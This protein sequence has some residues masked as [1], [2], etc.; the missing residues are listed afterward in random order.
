[1]WVECNFLIFLHLI[2]YFFMNKS[3]EVLRIKEC[4]LKDC[5]EF[6]NR[7]SYVGNISNRYPLHLPITLRNS[8]NFIYIWLHTY[9]ILNY[10]DISRWLRVSTALYFLIHRQSKY[11]PA[12]NI[13]A[14]FSNK[15]LIMLPYYIAIIHWY[16]IYFYFHC[17]NW[18]CELYLYL[19][20]H[21]TASVSM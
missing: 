14:T 21:V 11:V 10:S 5:Y 4:V 9:I 3:T 7:K 13:Q 8:R 12:M 15:N 6:K 19:V 1:M 20:I 2:V 16:F 18:F 17:L